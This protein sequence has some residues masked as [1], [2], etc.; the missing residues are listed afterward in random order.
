MRLVCAIY[1]MNDLVY[2]RCYDSWAED[3]IKES[4]WLCAEFVCALPANGCRFYIR[5]DRLS[6]A[7]VLDPMMTRRPK[8]DYIL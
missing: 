2:I 5:E 8:L 4:L 6:F 1:Y 7:L 3:C